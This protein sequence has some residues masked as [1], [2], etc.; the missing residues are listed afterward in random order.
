MHN[1]EGTLQNCKH[2]VHSPRPDIPTRRAAAQMSAHVSE[3]EGVR[4]RK[5]LDKVQIN[6]RNIIIIYKL[7][8]YI[9]YGQI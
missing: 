8:R 3:S 9:S 6:S 1:A 4:V 7:S 2:K 5:Y